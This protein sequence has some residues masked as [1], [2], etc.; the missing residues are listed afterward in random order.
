MNT[1]PSAAAFLVLFLCNFILGCGSGIAP[2]P[3]LNI[4][5]T[6][7]VIFIGD[8]ITFLWGQDQSFQANPNWISKGVS[9]DTS[10]LVAQ[11]FVKDAIS[12]Y[13]KTIHILVGTNDLNSSSWQLCTEP[14]YGVIIPGDICANLLY[15]VQTAEYY[16]IKVVIGT[17]PPWGCYDNPYCVN[18]NTVDQSATRYTHIS[19]LN[20]FLKAF[21]LRH[22]ITL[23]DYHTILQDSTGLHYGPNLTG[24]GVHPDAAGFSLMTPVAEA[25]LK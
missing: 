7:D 17:I 19:E 25:A 13:P 1:R 22:N 4:P 11:R 8:S 12:H 2:L 6:D 23:L 16:G 10:L 21:A 3:P 18:S 14:Q 20:G 24:D 15:M 5:Q 9:G